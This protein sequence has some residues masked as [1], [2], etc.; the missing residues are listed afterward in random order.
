M[1]KYIK[2]WHN[3]C[4]CVV[5]KIK[6][7]SVFEL[8]VVVIAPQGRRS[9]ADDQLARSTATVGSGGITTSFCIV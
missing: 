2:Q 3:V 4:G 7:C 8:S 1:C 5:V 9:S 6:K